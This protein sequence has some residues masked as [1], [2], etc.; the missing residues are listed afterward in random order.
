[1]ITIILKNGTKK[2]FQ[3]PTPVQEKNFW[4]AWYAMQDM[5]ACQNKKF[6]II[7]AAGNEYIAIGDIKNCIISQQEEVEKQRV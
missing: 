2:E 4:N 7:T 3:F 6:K 5:S 1:M